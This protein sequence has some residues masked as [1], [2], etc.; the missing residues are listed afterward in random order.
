MSSFA[1]T[2]R[3][4]SGLIPIASN[5]QIYYAL[6][7]LIVEMEYRYAFHSADQIGST[8]I[9]L[10]YEGRNPVPDHMLFFNILRIL[11]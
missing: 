5:R 3:E 4:A 10:A 1:D 7:T 11:V 6:E 8:F 2:T 9:S